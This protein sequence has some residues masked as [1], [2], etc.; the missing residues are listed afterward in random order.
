M[1]L[2][3]TS[4]VHHHLSA[5][6]EGTNAGWLGRVIR[7]THDQLVF[8]NLWRDLDSLVGDLN[9]HLALSN[10]AS[11]DRLL[12]AKQPAFDEENAALRSQVAALGGVEAVTSD[13][14]KMQQVCVS[15]TTADAPFT[16][17][18]LGSNVNICWQSSG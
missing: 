1:R 13:M 17:L 5:T 12:S 14:S 4:V 6:L 3:S 9:S 16:G 7:S 11:M 18:S 15:I 10:R 2:C 8:A